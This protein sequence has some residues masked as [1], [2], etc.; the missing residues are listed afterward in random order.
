MKSNAEAGKIGGSR[1]QSAAIGGLFFS[2]ILFGFLGSALGGSAA[3][4]RASNWATPVAGT[5]VENLYRV[6]PDLL[7][8]AQPSVAGFRQL[9]ALGVKSVLDLRKGDGDAGTARGTSLRLLQVPMTAWSLSDKGVVQALRILTDVKNRP[10][11]VHCQHG[12][13]RTGAI[14][15]LYR[16]VVQGWSKQDAL[17]EMNEGGFHHSSFFRNLDEY[18]SRADVAALRRELGILSP[19]AALTVQGPPA[20]KPGIV[21]SGLA[22]LRGPASLLAPAIGPGF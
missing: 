4:R 16:V 1:R 13:D 22:I 8:S 20:A 7:R 14:L 12:A 10:I 9:A 2:L 3:P 18:V 15:A 17:R 11:L 5:V 19:V 6:E 21:S